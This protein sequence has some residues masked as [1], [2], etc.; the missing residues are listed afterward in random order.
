VRGALDAP[1]RLR[2]KLLK[3][4]GVGSAVASSAFTVG[5]ERL[6]LLTED[7]RVLDEVD[8][9]LAVYQRDVARDLELRM[10]EIDRILLELER[11][12][13]DYFD[14]TLRIGRV[15]DLLNR[16][17]VQEG[18]ERQ[19][20]ADA[21]EQIERRIGELVDWLVEGDLQQWQAVTS[22]LAERRREHRGRIVG[23]EDPGRFHFDRTRLIDAV[24]REAQQ[25]VDSYDRRREARVLADGARNAV[26]AAAAA[27]AGAL[28]LGALVTAA[29]TSAAA[30]VTGLVLASVLAALGFFVLPAKRRQTKL[31]MRRK[32]T[33][34]RERLSTALHGQFEQEL[35]RSTGRIRESIAPYSRFVRAEGDRLRDV[36]R[37]LREITEALSS[38]RARIERRAA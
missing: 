24:S 16:S 15:L 36:E 4:L 1:A 17:R 35:E 13:H 37:D 34:V 20:V 22:H 8:R 28:G 10:A 6:S 19:V 3:P 11:R 31:E 26:A 7:F 32:I 14:E 30:D 5:Q 23:G 27:G 12:G 21:P 2:L 29:A 18:F 25:V 9:Q 33:D 38:L